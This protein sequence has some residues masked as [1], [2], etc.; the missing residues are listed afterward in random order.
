MVTQIPD[1]NEVYN[2]KLRALEQEL[3]LLGNEIVERVVDYLDRRN[4]NVTG[5]LRKSITYQVQKEIGQFRLT[6][7]SGVGLGGRNIKYD[8]FVH[9][10]TRPH[11]T[12]EKPIRKW[13]I[14][15]LGVRG[16]DVNKVTYLVRRKIA[17]KGT[18]ARPFL[19]TPFRLYRNILVRRIAAAI[20]RG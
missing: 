3:H 6:V 17:L 11:W 13:V 2:R 1:F 15:K 12:P 14:R 10:G 4:I 16:D 9:E 18:K 20:A 19:T 5:D 8:V 7:G